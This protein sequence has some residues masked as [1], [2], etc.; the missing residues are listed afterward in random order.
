M[1]NAACYIQNTV[2]CMTTPSTV[3]SSIAQHCLIEL[4][5]LIHQC[6]STPVKS[7]RNKSE[8]NVSK[9]ANK[10]TTIIVNAQSIKSN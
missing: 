2:T 5:H 10:L 8:N 9:P 6:T 4:I 7:V 3:N 1:Q